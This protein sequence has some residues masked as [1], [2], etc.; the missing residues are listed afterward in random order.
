MS[1]QGLTQAQERWLREACAAGDDG[2]YLPIM[3][4]VDPY[5]I[6]EAGYAEIRDVRRS[7]VDRGKT[8]SWTD[9][10]LVANMRGRKAVNA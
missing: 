5:A 6:A 9:S 1:V 8:I 3:A 4:G 2:A 10:Y 7:A